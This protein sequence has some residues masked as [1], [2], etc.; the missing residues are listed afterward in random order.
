MRFGSLLLTAGLVLT[1]GISHADTVKDIVNVSD[2]Q[3]DSSLFLS[4]SVIHDTTTSIGPTSDGIELLPGSYINI[5]GYNDVAAFSSGIGFYYAPQALIIGG[6]LNSIYY[7]AAGTDDFALSVNNLYHSPS[8]GGSIGV[9]GPFAPGSAFGFYNATVEVTSTPY[10]LPP[11]VTPPPATAVTP[12]PSA[13][14]LMGTGIL[15]IAGLR[16]KVQAQSA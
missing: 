11:T 15:S 9:T 2:V 13:F 10:D 6:L 7:G 12:E 4:F 14:V 1:A 3:G 8:V 16:K 5:D